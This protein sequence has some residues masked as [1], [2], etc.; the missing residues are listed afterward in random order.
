MQTKGLTDEFERKMVQIKKMCNLREP[1]RKFN[2]N[3]ETWE[4]SKI[5]LYYHTGEVY[6]NSYSHDRNLKNGTLVKRL[7]DCEKKSL[8]IY[9]TTYESRVVVD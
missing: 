2:L 5:W 6:A 8:D 4:V 9:V 3:K 1:W 7:I